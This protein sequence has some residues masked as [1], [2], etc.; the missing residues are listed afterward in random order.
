MINKQRLSLII[1]AAGV[2]LSPVILMSANG[3]KIEFKEKSWD[4]GNVKQGK[5]LDYVFKFTNKGDA[6]LIIKNVRTSCGC[7]AVLV[8]DKEIDPGKNGEIKVSFNTRGYGGN[9]SKYIYVESDDSSQPTAQLEVKASIDVPPRPIIE[10]DAYS[11]DL[12]LLLEGQDIDAVVKIMNKGEKELSLTFSHREAAFFEQGNAV[13]FPLKI[14]AGKDRDVEIRIPI[15]ERKSLLREYV[16]FRSNDPM[17]PNISLYLT[18]YIV[19][20]KQLKELFEKHK[21]ILN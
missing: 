4:F 2:L 5:V 8:K 12:G 11:K 10:L 1:L 18:G 19:S 14:A 3:P 15:G 7:T 20:K 21:D 16:L 13:T 17:R 6:P 9:V